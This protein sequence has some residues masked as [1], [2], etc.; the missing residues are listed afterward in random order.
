MAT[1][2]VNSM[3]LSSPDPEELA[4]W[5]GEVFEAPPMSMGTYTVIDLDG[6]FVMFDKRDD[7]TGPNREGA[8]VVL[9]VEPDD[10]EAVAGRIDALGGEWVSPLESRDGDLFATAKDPDGNWIQLVRLRDEMEAQMGAPTTP[11]SGIA[12]RDM[13]DTTRFYRNV[14]GMRVLPSEMG[15]SWIR[16]DRRTSMLAY[17][18]P[19]HVPATHTV[20]NIPTRDIDAT[21]ADLTARGVE[22]VRYDGAPQDDKGVMR[23]NGPD[24]AWFTDP[25][26][27]VLA[28]IAVDPSV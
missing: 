27:N 26:G 7:V 4:R 8:R 9:N 12:V 19:D 3:L 21:V 23:G 28:V 22:F 25:S 20:L 10:P 2:T 17:P 11:F 13:E 5:Y 18:K 1:A 6:F 15:T 16:I 14:L 24:I